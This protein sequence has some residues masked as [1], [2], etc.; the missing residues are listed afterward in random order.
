MASSQKELIPMRP[1]DL[2]RSKRENAGLSLERAAELSRIKPSVLQAIEAG[3]TAAIPSVYLRGYIRNYA[4][5]LG[6]DPVEIENQL[7]QVQGADPVVQSVFSVK[8]DRGRTENW[9]KA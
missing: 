7:E 5:A 3:E 1:A 2:L 4:R 9:L 8:S 6:L